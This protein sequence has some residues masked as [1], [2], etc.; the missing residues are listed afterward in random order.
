MRR[1]ARLRSKLRHDH[2]VE[3]L[4]ELLERAGPGPAAEEKAE[5][6]AKEDATK[7]APTDVAKQDPAAAGVLAL[8]K[9]AGNRAVGSMLSRWPV[10]GTQLLAQWPKE[11]QIILDDTVIP[12]ESLQ[13][14]AQNAGTVGSGN[15]NP[16]SSTGPG[17]V[18]VTL[19]MGKYSPDLFQQSLSGKGYKTVQIVFPTK[20]GKGVRFILTDVLISNY[21]ISGGGSDAP[22]ESIGLSFKKREL[23]HDPPPPPS[24]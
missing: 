23:S 15:A 13:E 19:K 21:S 20:D 11:P 4:E 2:D 24:R 6:E 10:F 14:Q 9:T 18:V 3:E 22:F 8:Q 12:I 1:R 5:A 16:P 17:E 7:S